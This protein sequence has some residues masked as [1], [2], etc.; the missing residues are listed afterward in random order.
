MVSDALPRGPPA[1]PPSVIPDQ[2]KGS[3]SDFG[4]EVDIEEAINRSGC[5]LEYYQLE[6]C[7]GEHNRD[8]RRCQEQ[9]PTCSRRCY[10]TIPFAGHC[11]T[12]TF[13]CIAATFN[14]HVL[15]LLM[16]HCVLCSHLEPCTA[17]LH[18]ATCTAVGA[19]SITSIRDVGYS[20]SSRR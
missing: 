18:P 20:Y 10:C 11:C 16:L 15:S 2:H 13:F 8:W 7:L 17:V 5:S 6:E 9:V 19:A 1:A 14:G 4:G 3:K 12:R